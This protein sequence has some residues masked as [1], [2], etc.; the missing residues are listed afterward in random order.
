MYFFF[1][2]IPFTLSSPAQHGVERDFNV[3]YFEWWE[4]DQTTNEYIGFDVS[5]ERVKEC[6]RTQGPF[7]GLVGFSQG[8]TFS[9]ILCAHNQACIAAGEAPI[10]PNLKFVVLLAA[11]PPRDPR[12]ETLMSTPIAIPAISIYGQTDFLK[13]GILVLHSRFANLTV[14]V[15]SGS[16]EPPTN[17]NGEA[18]LEALRAFVA[19]LAS[20]QASQC[21]SPRL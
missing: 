8:G 5:L 13:E 19:A 4:L 10:F 11:I 9:A 18:A 12:F 14:A 2:F 15:H 7:D 3:P 6:E 17:K 21:E 1:K 16:H 20:G